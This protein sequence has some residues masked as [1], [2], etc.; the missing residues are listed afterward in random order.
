MCVP[1]TPYGHWRLVLASTKV[2]RKTLGKRPATLHVDSLAAACQR[3]ADPAWSVDRFSLL[4][5][6][7]ATLLR[8]PHLLCLLQLHA[9]C[10]QQAG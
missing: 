7:A 3:G 2:H 4:R 9:A 5:Q 6:L 8:L 1:A 10:T